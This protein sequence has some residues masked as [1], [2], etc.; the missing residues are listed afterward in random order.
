MKISSLTRGFLGGFLIA[1]ALIAVN[2]PPIGAIAQDVAQEAPG[3]VSFSPILQTAIPYVIELF[4][5]GMFVL[6]SLVAAWVKRKW[7]IDAEAKIREIEARH[8]EALHSAIASGVGNLIARHA[9]EKKLEVNVGSES[10]AYILRY[11]RD[12]VPDALSSLNPS[13]DV[14][15]KIA[16]R[17]AVKIAGA[18]PLAEI[19]PPEFP[20]AGRVA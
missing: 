8:R 7:N 4:L 20:D 11:I 19:R 15:A 6:A 16:T 10:L 18:Q 5:T 12:S 2:V 17:E 13:P 9:L 3:R 1:A 14:I